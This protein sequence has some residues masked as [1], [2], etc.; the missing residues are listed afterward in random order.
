M[1]AEPP[2]VTTKVAVDYMFM[3]DEET[4]LPCVVMRNDRDLWVSALV[5]LCK[6]AAD[7]SLVKRLADELEHAGVTDL[8]FKSDDETAMKDLKRAVVAELRR[9]VPTARVT[10][11]ESP[12]AC[13][14]PTGWS[15]G[16]Y[17]RYR[18]VRGLF[19]PARVD[20]TDWLRLRCLPDTLSA[21]GRS[22]LLVRWPI[23]AR[24]APGARPRGSF[25]WASFTLADCR[26]GAR[27][28]FL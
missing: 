14:R 22:S 21:L 9:R 12:Q 17:G 6:G 7:A 10:M 5:G 18:A 15:S 24:S 4:S 20:C 13:T 1:A 26:S 16:A 25:A 11:E 27:P 19:S 3:G 8:T 28:F 2:A 23:G